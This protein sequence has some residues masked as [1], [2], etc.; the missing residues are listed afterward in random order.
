MRFFIPVLQSQLPPIE[1]GDRIALIQPLAHAPPL[2][3][4]DLSKRRDPAEADD[5]HVAQFVRH[6][7]VLVVDEQ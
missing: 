5:V 1:P 7:P 2:D 4:W 3:E 6:E